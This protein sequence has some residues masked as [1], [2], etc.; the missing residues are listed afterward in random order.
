[1][2]GPV[3]HT[4]DIASDALHQG[5]DGWLLIVQ[6][7]HQGWPQGDLQAPVVLHQQLVL[8]DDVDG[9]LAVVAGG[10]GDREAEDDLVGAP[11]LV[12]PALSHRIKAWTGLLKGV[13]ATDQD[14]D[15]R[16][17]EILPMNSIDMVRHMGFL[18]KSFSTLFTSVLLLIFVTHSMI[19]GKIS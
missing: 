15:R 8:Q 12:V 16:Q 2:D 17:G 9:A 1:M 7:C 13:E 11:V 14:K 5:S 4:V 6:G 3:I 18:C 19:I 10:G